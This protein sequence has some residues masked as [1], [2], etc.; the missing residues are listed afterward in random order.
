MS[1]LDVLHGIFGTNPAANS[2]PQRSSSLR[3]NTA[4]SGNRHRLGCKVAGNKIV[5]SAKRS[6]VKAIDSTGQISVEGLNEIVSQVLDLAQRVHAV[7]G[8]AESAVLRAEAAVLKADTAVTKAE[9]A[10]SRADASFSKADSA[11]SRAEVA[12]LKAEAAAKRSE[13][14]ANKAGLAAGKSELAA[15]GREPAIVTE[16]DNKT[17]KLNNPVSQIA[18]MGMKLR[19]GMKNL[20]GTLLNDE[21][22]PIDSEYYK[23]SEPVHEWA[24]SFGREDVASGLVTVDGENSIPKVAPFIMQP[25]EKPSQERQKTARSVEVTKKADS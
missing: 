11:C 25:A 23:G 13:L 15:A 2:Q 9:T 17:K 24:T 6:R 16:E 7:A 10:S 20:D 5:R 18:L 3:G 1:F 21:E 4:S 19:S 12:V 22:G 14:A 8:Q